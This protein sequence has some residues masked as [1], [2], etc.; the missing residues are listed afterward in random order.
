MVFFHNVMHQSEPIKASNGSKFILRS[1]VMFE[2][3]PNVL[4]SQRDSQAY[5]IYRRAEEVSL[6]LMFYF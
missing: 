4:I 2:R 5:E 6:L 3:L 1:D